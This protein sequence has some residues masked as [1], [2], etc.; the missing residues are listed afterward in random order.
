MRERYGF[1]IT[2]RKCHEMLPDG[3]RR[4]HLCTLVDGVDTGFSVGYPEGCDRY[5]G[6]VYRRTAG[7]FVEQSAPD[8]LDFMCHHS[9]LPE[10]S[11]LLPSQQE[12]RR[13][14]AEAKAAR[15]SSLSM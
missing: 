13:R 5:E 3:S 15:A 2:S 9:R 14:I 4:E 10:D 12:H 7:R 11:G 8:G 6:A 1:V